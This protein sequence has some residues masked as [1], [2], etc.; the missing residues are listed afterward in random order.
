MT[1]PFPTKENPLKP[2][3]RNAPAEHDPYPHDI[4][5]ALL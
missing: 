3:E 1:W 5:D 4:E 2:P